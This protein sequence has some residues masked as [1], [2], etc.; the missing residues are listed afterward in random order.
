MF[1]KNKENL[2]YKIYKQAVFLEREQNQVMMLNHKVKFKA[3]QDLTKR[4]SLLTSHKID[5]RS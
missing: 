1:L 5:G 4:S 3:I 2:T